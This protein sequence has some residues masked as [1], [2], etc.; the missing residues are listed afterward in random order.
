MAESLALFQDERP[1]AGEAKWDWPG[2]HGD[3]TPISTMSADPSEL[4]LH[5]NT[6]LTG[7]DQEENK[8]LSPELVVA[9]SNITSAKPQPLS[10]EAQLEPHLT[11]EQVRRRLRATTQFAVQKSTAISYS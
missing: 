8:L 5:T 2:T 4:C 10:A 9:A 3:S 1:R 11:H 6:E 7:V